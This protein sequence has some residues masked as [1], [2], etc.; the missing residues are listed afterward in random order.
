MLQSHRIDLV[1]LD[2]GLPG[3]G[4]FTVQQEI[5]ADAALRRIAVVIV[6]A[7]TED[8]SHLNVE[9]VLRKP[10]LTTELVNTVRKC[11]RLQRDHSLREL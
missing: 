10:V 5:E 11:L 2:L 3:V 6:T 1:V 8:L 4:G 7:S 9:C